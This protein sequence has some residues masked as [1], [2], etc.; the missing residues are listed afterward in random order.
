MTEDLRRR[1]ETAST[2]GDIESA[3]TV[4]R[5]LFDINPKTAL[6]EY[7]CR[8]IEQVVADKGL[9]TYRIAFLPSFTLEPVAA[10]L[11][12]RTFI[13]GWSATT[14]FWP[15]QQ[16]DGVLSSPGDLDAFAPDAVALML[17]LEDCVPTLA[18]THLAG[19]AQLDDEIELFLEHLQSAVS[20]F[21]QRSATPVI[22]NTLIPMTRGIERHF[23]RRVRDGRQERVDRLNRAISEIARTQSGVYLFDY[24]QCVTDAGRVA[25]YD[26]VKDHHTRSALTPTG[27]AAL[28]DELAEFLNALLGVRRKVL[29]V[30]LDNTLWGGVVGEDG[31]DG[32]ALAGDYPGNAYH[33][34]QSFLANLRASGIALA[35]VSKNNP[36]DAHEVFMANPDMPVSWDHFSSRQIGWQD[37]VTGLRA[38]SE[39]LNVGTDSLVFVDDSATEC[40]MIRTYLPEVK[41]INANVDPSLL[42][43]LVLNVGGLDAVMLTDEDLGRTDSYKANVDRRSL[44]LSSTDTSSFLQRLEINLELRAPR[45][46]EFERV[47]QLCN[48]TNQFNLTTKRYTLAD[49]QMMAES[50]EFCLRIGRMRDR[51]GDYGLILVM[52]LRMGSPLW[53]IETLLM[54]CRVIGKKIEAAALSFAD[55]LARGQGA[56]T[57]FGLYKPTKKNAQ[58]SM[59]Y[60][61]FGFAATEEEGVF[62]REISCSPPLLWP[63]FIHQP[64]E[65]NT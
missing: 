62:K 23:D 10:H 45:S 12:L 52:V 56:E 20:A 42:A 39:A 15:Y 33:N 16:W 2:S 8:K 41:V 63:D 59:L 31:V 26:P 34:F 43:G 27:L 64:S 25:W 38:I 13:H 49:I 7:A 24:A 29:A 22:L 1:L 36:E 35:T 19:R 61:N 18:Y 53:E 28:A 65:I 14:A 30:D 54:S 58:V 57:L 6:I 46:G 44:E 3:R 47:A 40:E 51:F 48:K 17:H 5:E 4:V 50:P 21:R 11:S 60:P 9:P 55:N 32:L 37:K